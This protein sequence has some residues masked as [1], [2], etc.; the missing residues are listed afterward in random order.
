M[1]KYMNTAL[2]LFYA[3]ILFTIGCSESPSEQKS[4]SDLSAKTPGSDA[5]KTHSPE[6]TKAKKN[7]GHVKQSAEMAIER[8]GKENKYLFLVF[9]KKGDQKSKEMQQVV[10]QAQKELSGKANFVHIDVADQNEQATIRKYGIDRSPIPITLVMAPNGAIVTG[11]PEKVNE[12]Q[13]RNAFVSPKMAEIVKVM[14]DRKLV[15]LYIANRSMKYYRKNLAL[16]QETARVDLQGQAKVVEV[17]PEDK[18]EGSLLKQCRVETPVKEPSLFI[19]NGGRIVGQLAGEFVKQVLL[20]RTISG[21]G[22]GSGGSCC[23][24][25]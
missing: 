5:M 8:A 21:C 7:P 13:L 18:K 6:G 9:Y 24:G 25:R 15:Y 17:N 1:I 11:F 4:Q 16:L 12:D 23:P 19:L 10:A 14:Q 20:A 22:V 2:F 3:G